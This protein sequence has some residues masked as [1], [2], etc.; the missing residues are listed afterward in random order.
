MGPFSFRSGVKRTFA[1]NR[2]EP[3]LN[4][5]GWTKYTCP[6]AVS[7]N[8]YRNSGSTLVMTA[9]TTGAKTGGLGATG[10]GTGAGAAF[11]M[12]QWRIESSDPASETSQR[13]NEPTVRPSRKAL[14]LIFAGGRLG[15]VKMAVAWLTPVYAMRA[16]SNSRMRPLEGS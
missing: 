12:N 2:S 4:S 7:A 3:L 13:M 6:A 1:F 8:P 15:L 10:T 14:P 11:T 16:G 5:L 9:V